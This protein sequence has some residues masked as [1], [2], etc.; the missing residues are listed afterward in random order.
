MDQP[1]PLAMKNNYEGIVTALRRRIFSS[2]LQVLFVFTFI[3]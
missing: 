2:V 3:G 1:N